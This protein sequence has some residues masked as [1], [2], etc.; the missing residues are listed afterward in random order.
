MTV[1]CNGDRVVVQAGRGAAGGERGGRA[2]AGRAAR[3]AARAP[4]LPGTSRHHTQTHTHRPS[5]IP[6]HLHTNS[7]NSKHLY[8]CLKTTHK[9]RF[10]FT[11]KH[12]TYLQ[13]LPEIPLHAHIFLHT[14]TNFQVP[15]KH[16]IEHMSNKSLQFSLLN[17]IIS[18]KYYLNTNIFWTSDSLI[19]SESFTYD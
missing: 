1:L 14:P 6:R 17:E 15:H 16:D 12:V 5:T 8:T 9:H 19:P 2:V 7:N 13:T 4:A 3:A 10:K 11:L 18:V